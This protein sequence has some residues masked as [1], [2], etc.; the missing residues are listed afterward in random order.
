MGTRSKRRP[1]KSRPV[2]YPKQ[3][4][5]QKRRTGPLALAGGALALFAAAAAIAVL[6]SGEQDAGPVRSVGL[7]AT[8][9]YHSLLVS[10][11]DPRVLFLG[12][13]QGLYRSSNGG[14]TWNF[15]ELSGQDAMNLAQPTAKTVWAAGHNVLAKS[16]DGGTTW[17]DVRP[18]GLPGLDVHGFAVQPG[19]PRTLYAA[20]A[21]QGLYRSRDGGRSFSL[22][23]PAV[24][25]SVMALAINPRGRILA[26]DMEQGLL[27]STDAGRSWRQGLAEGV[28]GIALNPQNSK[29]G[30]A[31]GSGIFRSTTGGESWEQVL[32]LPEGGGPVTW[33]PSDPRVAYVVGFDRTLYRSA[34][35]GRTW[36]PVV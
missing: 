28:M 13:H 3:R 11:R 21:G 34:D 25:P 7:P 10:P 24:G 9:D 18:E 19:N 33:A 2:Q 4:A 30:L 35:G 22:V 27:M 29:L 6:R 31:T 16:T 20:I 15:A 8:S 32:R 1:T 23:S 5:G 12:T 36:R 14:R 26:G 17:S